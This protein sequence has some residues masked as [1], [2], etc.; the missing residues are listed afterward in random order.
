MS[1]RSREKLGS[2]GVVSFAARAAPAEVGSP[3]TVRA[4]PFCPAC[5]RATASG[6]LS[7]PSKSSD[8]ASWVRGNAA[9]LHAKQVNQGVLGVAG[10]THAFLP[11]EPINLE[12]HRTTSPLNTCPT[13]RPSN[14]KHTKAGSPK[15]TAGFAPGCKASCRFG[16]TGFGMA[17]RSMGGRLGLRG[18][19]VR[20]RWG[21]MGLVWEE[22]VRS[23]SEF[24]TP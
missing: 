22:R 4:E 16:A 7:W 3:V 14:G 24:R 2:R 11:N 15:T 23:T 18:L 17:S 9:D 5:G 21:S 8:S 1:T 19:V 10:G 13:A 6:S 12:R 20:W